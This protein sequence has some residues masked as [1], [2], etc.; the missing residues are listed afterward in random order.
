TE[1]ATEA[2]MQMAFPKPVGGGGA[3]L[4]PNTYPWLTPEIQ[5]T[6][7]GNE[8]TPYRLQSDT[9]FYRYFG[10]TS[11]VSPAGVGYFTPQLFSSAE[12][13]RRM[14]ALSPEVTGNKA[15]FVV[16]VTVPA[17]TV[18]LFG[19]V[20]AQ[21]PTDLFPGGGVQVVVGNPRDPGI[22]YGT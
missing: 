13:A 17:G 8:A 14:L 10:P 20:A 4:G 5:S 6:F 18:V 16:S 11:M 12:R 1:F 22:R 3:D 2:V 19:P 9:T 7:V 15:E 21:R